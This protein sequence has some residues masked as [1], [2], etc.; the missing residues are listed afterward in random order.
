MAFIA[1]VSFST[2]RKVQLERGMMDQAEFA[3]IGETTAKAIT[4]LNMWNATKDYPVVLPGDVK[5]EF[6]E[7]CKYVL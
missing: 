6:E 4:D 3:K 7:A 1:E 2:C 5:T